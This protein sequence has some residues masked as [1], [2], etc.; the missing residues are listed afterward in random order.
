MVLRIAKGGAIGAALLFL[1]G[2]AAFLY[3]STTWSWAEFGEGWWWYST[4]QFQ[5]RLLLPAGLTIT[6]AL[7][8]VCLGASIIGWRRFRRTELKAERV[9]PQKVQQQKKKQQSDRLLRRRRLAMDREF[10]RPHPRPDKLVDQL[11]GCVVDLDARSLHMSPG[12]T[13][14][15][16]NLHLE[17]HQHSLTT[18]T[19]PVYQLILNQ[20]REMLS[21][22]ESGAGRINLRSSR[23]VDNLQIKIQPGTLGF[24]TLIESTE[25]ASYQT[26]PEEQVD[27][28]MESPLS[29][30]EARAP[31]RRKR[32]ITLARM[33]PRH[34]SDPATGEFPLPFS[35]EDDT[36]DSHIALMFGMDPSSEIEISPVVKHKVIRPKGP[37]EQWL[38]LTLVTVSTLCILL[39]FWDALGWGGHYW[40]TQEPTA[41]WRNVTIEIRSTPRPGTVSIRGKELGQTP[42]KITLPCRGTKLEVLVSADGFM[43]WQSNF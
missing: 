32:S 14:V 4:A 11:F 16:L 7:G 31:L 34:R 29:V 13:L 24:S 43:V 21:L 9:P 35:G 41:P 30:H 36:T 8:L 2:S 42:I 1:L 23:R 20:L 27:P 26:S 3:G 18:I 25:H 38:R 39:Y 17:E 33:E 40:T 22:E 37:A 12:P 19:F 10:C 5:G 6:L 28:A 15:E